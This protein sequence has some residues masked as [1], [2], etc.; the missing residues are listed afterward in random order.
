[1]PV[2]ALHAQGHTRTYIHTH[3]YTWYMY[4]CWPRVF[5]GEGRG[6]HVEDEGFQ[7]AIVQLGLALPVMLSLWT[8]EGVR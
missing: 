6:G 8:V 5:G 3:V 2:C 1:M 7:E 4:L